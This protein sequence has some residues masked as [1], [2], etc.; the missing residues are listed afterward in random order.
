VICSPQAYHRVLRGP[1]ASFCTHLLSVGQ[2]V[3]VDPA[4]K[5]TRVRVSER[6]RAPRN[7]HQIAV[8]GRIPLTAPTGD[9]IPRT[10]P[11]ACR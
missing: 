1:I 7:I 4:N 9:R 8:R 5:M 6:A 10:A 11:P 2:S 3:Q